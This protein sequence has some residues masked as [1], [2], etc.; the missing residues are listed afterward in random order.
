MPPAPLS[1]SS[2]PRVAAPD[3]TPKRNTQPAS[4]KENA[5]NIQTVV[6]ESRDGQYKDLDTTTHEE[7]PFPSTPGIRLDLE[8]LVANTEDAFNHPPPLGTPGDH[9][10][11]QNGPTS[12]DMTGSMGAGTQ[13]SQRS[14]KGR[15]RMRSSS[16]SSSQMERSTHFDNEGD[17]AGP[18]KQQRI[19][20]TPNNDPTQELWRRYAN[21]N[22]E[23]KDLNEDVSSFARLPPSS[24]ITPSTESRD[25]AIRRT[26]SCGIEWPTSK[27][28]RR[29]V[30]IGDTQNRTKIIFAASRRE[31]LARDRPKTSRVSLLVEKIHESLA[32][33][34]RMEDEP[35][36]SSP[37]PDRHAALPLSQTSPTRSPSKLRP[38]SSHRENNP[39]AASEDP[40]TVAV[41]KDMLDEF[42]DDDF[43]M[44][45]FE[46]VEKRISQ[47]AVSAPEPV[48]PN[49]SQ[50]K[51]YER[52]NEA[53]VGV[54]EVPAPPKVSAAVQEF[55]DGAEFLEDGLEFDEFDDDDDLF[56]TELETLAAKVESQPRGSNDQTNESHAGSCQ[57]LP[58]IDEL[59][60]A[61]DDDDDLLLQIADDVDVG[62]PG[63]GSTSQ[64]R[65][66]GL[67]TSQC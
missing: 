6:D 15:K 20:R 8:D 19:L 7:K 37:L 13:K 28:K 67:D 61:F 9:V 48:A 21:A 54:K 38:A 10:L 62:K 2:Q 43:D 22:G 33:R 14:Q 40:N 25:S 58:T 47:V 57:Q 49:T 3:S 35:S 32:Q 17:P 55:D 39:R 27:P 42:A 23:R 46:E 30:E 50:L 24:P 18:N 5:V 1:V 52:P 11:W 36:S 45:F 16:P 59:D 53:D 51:M 34:A 31:I 44:D 4:G 41:D 12:S 29:R 63:I 64:V 56:T 26:V 65:P 60:G 66:P